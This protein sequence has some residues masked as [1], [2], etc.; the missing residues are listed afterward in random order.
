MAPPGAAQESAAQPPQQN[1]RPSLGGLGGALARRALKK[2]NDKDAE[3]SGTGRS[4]IMTI[5]HELLKVTPT[6]TDADVAIPTGF[7]QKS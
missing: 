2:D 1:T 5:E 7:K 3:A 4:T 6:V